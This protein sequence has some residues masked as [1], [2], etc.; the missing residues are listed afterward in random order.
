ML[1]QSMHSE[2]DRFRLCLT[3]NLNLFLRDFLDAAALL[4]LEFQSLD[5]TP[6]PRL[7]YFS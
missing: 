1:L 3:D 6:S 5:E 7:C 2:P 4:M